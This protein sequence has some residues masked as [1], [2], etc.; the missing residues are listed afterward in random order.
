MKIYSLYIFKITL[1]VNTGVFFII[2]F[3]YLDKIE[4]NMQTR[5]E[6]NGT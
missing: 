4:I 5:I 6:K 3:F 2:G 1:L